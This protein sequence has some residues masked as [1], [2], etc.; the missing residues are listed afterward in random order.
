MPVREAVIQSVSSYDARY[1][2]PAGAG[3]DAVH[4]ESEYCLAVT[5]LKTDGA[6]TGT[7]IGRFARP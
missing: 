2:L 3:T 7:A 6:L 4:S 5:L 1:P